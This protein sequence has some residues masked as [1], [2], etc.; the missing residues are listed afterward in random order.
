M[1]SLN[2]RGGPGSVS[3]KGGS[4][5]LVTSQ[6]RMSMNHESLCNPVLAA[7]IPDSIFIV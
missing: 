2:G 6:G 7:D 3:S 4:D 1:K 5:M